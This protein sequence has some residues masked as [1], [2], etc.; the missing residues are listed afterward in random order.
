MF[1]NSN[2]QVI[3]RTVYKILIFPYVLSLLSVWYFQA[4]SVLSTSTI[5]CCNQRRKNL[6]HGGVMEKVEK[7]V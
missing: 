7:G 1:G 4:P 6:H 3:F 5:V 2:Y